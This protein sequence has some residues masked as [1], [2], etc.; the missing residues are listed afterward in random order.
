M[1]TKGGNPWFRDHYSIGWVDICVLLETKK[2][3]TYKKNKDA[4]LQYN[5][6]VDSKDVETGSDHLI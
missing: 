2:I 3:I 5:H 6:L 4:H 1:R